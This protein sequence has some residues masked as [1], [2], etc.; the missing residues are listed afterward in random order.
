[1]PRAQFLLLIDVALAAFVSVDLIRALR[2]GRA[3]GRGGTITRRGRPE[4]FWRHIYASYAVLAA[5]AGI[6]LWILI[7]PQTF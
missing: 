3:R 1:M 5:C 6:L 4:K 7:A 2:T